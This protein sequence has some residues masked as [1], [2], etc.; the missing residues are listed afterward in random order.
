MPGFLAQV[1]S[2]G[3]ALQD[4]GEEELKRA[5]EELR[6]SLKKEGLRNDH[7]SRAFALIRELASRTLG[8]RHFETQL[9]GGRV[10]LNGMVAEMETGE[11]K[12]LTATLAAGTAALAG[13]PVHI[14]TVNDYLTARDAEWMKPLYE[15]LGLQVGCIVH[16]MPPDRRKAAYN[17]DV[18]YCTNKEIAFDYLR[19]WIALDGRV[20]PLRLQVEYLYGKGA[21]VHSLLLR[22]LHYGIVDEADSVLI[23]EARTPLIISRGCGNRD[24][25]AFM[26]QA[27]Q[28]ARTLGNGLHYK[29]DHGSRKVDLTDLGRTRIREQAE[30]LGPLWTGAVRREEIVRL[31][32]AALYRFRRDEEYLVNEGK[33]QIIDEFTGRVMADRSYEKG[34]H[35]LIEIKEGCEMTQRVETIARISYQRFFRRYLH[36]SGMT[37]TAKEVQSEMWSV[38][39][40]PVVR[41]PTHRTMRRKSYPDRVFG[42]EGEKWV[43]VGER[44]RE[45][46]ARGRPVLVGTRSV[47]ASEKASTVLTQRGLQHQILNAKQDRQEAEIIARAG[48][49]GCI[50]VATNMAGRG[51]DIKLGPGIEERGGLHVILTERHEAGRIDRQL[52]GRCGRQGDAGSYAA[53]LSL[54]DPLLKAGAKGPVKWLVRLL[55]YPACP[56]RRRLAAFVIRRSQKRIERFHLKVR[57]TLL[58]E[59][60]RKG[61]MLSFSGR[62]E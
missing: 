7:V 42:T 21:R 27:I 24:E 25:A 1:E 40:L 6:S 22:G 8:T 29:L 46:H 43:A 37:G 60:E 56:F 14:I 50:T 38:Y 41:I 32:L 23:D 26:Q 39:G 47:A 28:I 13:I 58:R 18:T 35:Q 20:N 3:G 10:L 45:M 62:S 17:S 11:G 34:L 55:A 44:V 5:A 33:I 59:D 19:D 52:A 49:T 51:T 48:E 31:A 53:V 4:L 30:S 15:A 54:E 9:I 12:T 36:L 16:D 61:D 57:K 2:R